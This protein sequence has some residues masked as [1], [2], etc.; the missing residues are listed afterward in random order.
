M[1]RVSIRF[2]SLLC[3]AL[4][5]SVARAQTPPASTDHRHTA[6]PQDPA[7]AALARLR[8][9]QAKHEPAPPPPAHAASTRHALPPHTASAKPPAPVRTASTK[10][11]AH[12]SVQPKP[13]A[14]AAPPA[15]AP[16]AAPAPAKPA[17]DPNKGTVTGLPI[18]RY[19]SLRTGDVN[20]RSGPGTRYP[21]EWVYKR[22]D[23]PV[24]IE[25]EFEV[26][27]LVR[28]PDGVKG[29]V[30]QA[31]LT[32]R[33]SFFVTA[34]EQVMRDA[35]SD[36]ASPVAKIEPGVVG[37]IRACDATSDWCQVEVGDVRGWLK[38]GAFWGTLPGEA[39]GG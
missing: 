14:P 35:A 32:G 15:P 19:A 38:R 8:A 37:R 9:K 7:E 30:H 29:W 18:P 21:I 5:A 3:L 6:T 31:T 1:R 33:R 39:V 12:A 22:R 10:H 20:L 25:R 11:P 16:V 13:A 4:A 34:G 24:E 28:D 2:A 36:T 23:L 17:P 26:W 27:R